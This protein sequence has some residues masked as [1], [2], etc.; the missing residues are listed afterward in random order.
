APVDRQP[1]NPSLKQGA[2]WPYPELPH[3]WFSGLCPD[4]G[5]FWLSAD[6]LLWA[7][8]GGCLPPLIT[9][10]PPDSLG[11]LGQPGTTILIGDRDVNRGAFSGGRF[12]GG[13][14]LDDDHIF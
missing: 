13:V 14:W 1:W 3:R 10:S 11:I 12:V 6:Y 7:M 4:L 9:T 2:E 8:K 5:Q